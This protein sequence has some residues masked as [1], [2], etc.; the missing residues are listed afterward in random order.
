VDALRVHLLLASLSNVLRAE[1]RRFASEH[2]LALAQLEALHYLRMCNRYSDTPLAVAEFLGA[3]KGTVSQ[4]LLALEKKG[5]IEKRPDAEDRR[6][7]HLRLTRKGRALADASLP[8]PL[9]EETSTTTDAALALEELLRSMQRARN[10]QSFGVCRSCAHFERTKDGFVCGLT[11]E[12]LST[13]D[14][15][16]ICREHALVQINR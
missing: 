15:T 11:R 12:P 7:S 14:S 13:E 2:G 5:L 9:L 1:L 6:V 8:A 10:Q 3:T 16:K 4:T